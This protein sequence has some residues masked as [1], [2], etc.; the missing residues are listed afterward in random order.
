MSL[1]K[2]PWNEYNFK[3]YLNVKENEINGLPKGVSISTM[4]AKCKLGTK[5]NL[6][7]IYTHFKLNEDDV[8]TV[9]VN[10]EKLR[11]IL[12]VKEKKRRVSKRKKTSKPNPFYNQITI[13]MRIYEG[14]KGV[15]YKKEKDGTQTRCLDKIKKI[16][17]KLFKNGSIQMS[18]VKNYKYTNRALNKLIYRLSEAIDGNLEFVENKEEMN[19]TDFNIYMINSNYQINIH[20]NRKKLFDILSKKKIKS[21]YEKCIR[22]CVIVKYCP[23]IKNDEEKEVSLFIFEKGNI[24]IT[25]ARNLEHIVESYNY[26]NNIIFEHVDEITKKDEEIESDLIFQIYD[27][28]IKEHGFKLNIDI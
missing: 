3:D 11:T 18:G 24:I 1:N 19:I 21:S 8:L 20:V 22:A 13:V 25:G 9:K 26:I 12:P 17:L 27:K 15:T 16:N 4:C 2:S 23:T 6:N 10:R 14:D 7:E 5:L 28:V